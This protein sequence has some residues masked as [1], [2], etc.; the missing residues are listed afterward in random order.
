MMSLILDQIKTMWKEPFV[1]M[2]NEHYIST[3]LK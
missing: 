1:A 2:L 3:A